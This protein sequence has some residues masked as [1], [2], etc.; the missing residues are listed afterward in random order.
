MSSTTETYLILTVPGLF[1]TIAPTIHALPFCFFI[2]LTSSV[3][4][5]VE[6]EINRPPDVIG[7]AT[8]WLHSFD[9]AWPSRTFVR[10]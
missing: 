1:S 9:G 8:I 4:L 2:R 3:A 7:Q 5:S 10:D 6:I